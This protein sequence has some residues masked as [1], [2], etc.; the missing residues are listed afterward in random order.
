M[1]CCSR[2]APAR[3][4]ALPKRH[5]QFD[6]ALLSIELEGHG[7]L[8][9]DVDAK[10]AVELDLSGD[11]QLDYRVRWEVPVKDTA[12]V[13]DLDWHQAYAGSLRATSR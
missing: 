10:R 11:L 1:C 6:D 5:N 2:P 9:W 4:C 13:V 3:Q 12:R 8:A 7:E